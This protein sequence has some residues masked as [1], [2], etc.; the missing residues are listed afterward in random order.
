ARAGAAEVGKASPVAK[1]RQWMERHEGARARGKRN[2]PGAPERAAPADALAGEREIQ[3]RTVG[4]KRAPVAQRLEPLAAR[5]R[6]VRNRG[7]HAVETDR[8]A[9][10]GVVGHRVGATSRRQPEAEVQ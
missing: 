1:G 10:D 4:G 7:I 6:T 9:Q 2:P 3:Q 8:S 5:E